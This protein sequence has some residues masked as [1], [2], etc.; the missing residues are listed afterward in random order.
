[1]F[2]FDFCGCDK[3]TLTKSSLEEERV[4]FSFQVMVYHGRK[5][6]QELK[7]ELEADN[8]EGWCWLISSGITL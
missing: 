2:Y 6:K 4:Y 5:S 7:Q 8:M 1:M 3:N